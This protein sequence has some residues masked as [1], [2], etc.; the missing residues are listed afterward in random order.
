LGREIA[1]ALARAGADVACAARNAR[2][3]KETADDINALGRRAI[4]IPTDVTQEQQ[5]V[6]LTQRTAE[7]FGQIDILFYCAGMMHAGSSI[8]MALA[9][10]EM[11]LK[12]NLTGA[13]VTC[14]E[15]AKIMKTNGGG[16]IIL[17]GSAFVDRVLP[18]SLAYVVSKAGLSQMIRNLAFEWAR[19]GIRVNGIAPGYFETDMPAAVLGDP[20]ARER[21]LRRIPLRRV[22]VPA[23]IGPLAVYLAGG[24]SDYMTGEIICM[25]GGQASHIS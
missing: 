8:D 3:L 7:E 23:E 22:G 14:R 20:K 13:Y 5:V 4:C 15:A 17:I 19:Y 18:Y 21:V 24:S 2:K 10:W 12:T 1:L 11:V 16:H 25:D 6:D 9:D